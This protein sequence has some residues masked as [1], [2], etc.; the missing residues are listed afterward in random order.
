MNLPEAVS[1]AIGVLNKHELHRI[2]I[3][4]ICSA[5]AAMFDP[6]QFF[7]QAGAYLFRN[8][9]GTMKR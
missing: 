8:C 4:I 7:M 3:F 9:R 2:T 1:P 5:V 6:S